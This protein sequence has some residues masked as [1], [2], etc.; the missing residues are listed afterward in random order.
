MKYYSEYF[1]RRQS[2]IQSAAHLCLEHLVSRQASR[3]GP[4]PVQGCES[5]LFKCF[6]SSLR[7]VFSKTERLT[8][9]LLVPHIQHEVGSI[10]RWKPTSLAFILHFVHSGAASTHTGGDL[11]SHGQETAFS[12]DKDHK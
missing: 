2:R 10:R 12:D 7:S 6:I 4:A 3:W 5:K 9:Q 11:C 8:L 1:C